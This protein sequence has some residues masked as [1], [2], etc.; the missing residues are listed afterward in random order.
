[1]SSAFSLPVIACM[2]WGKPQSD[3]SVE[4]HS[5]AE[6]VFGLSGCDPAGAV[7][8]SHERKAKTSDSIFFINMLKFGLERA[9]R[10]GRIHETECIYRMCLSCLMVARF[11][12]AQAA[13]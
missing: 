3:R 9:T 8:F 10:I 6:D 2:P 1:M 4:T 7:H 13:A 5:R 12:R 11:I